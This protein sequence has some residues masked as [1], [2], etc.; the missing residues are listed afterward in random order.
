MRACHVC[1]ADMTFTGDRDAWGEA[2]WG[3]SHC[4][5]VPSH[6]VGDPYLSHILRLAELQ[7]T[8]P[9]VKRAMNFRIE[10]ITP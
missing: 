10:N 7:R 2:V 3:I 6:N 5:A 1:G 4:S 9:D 8:R